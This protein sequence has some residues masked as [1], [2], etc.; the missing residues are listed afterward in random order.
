MI[1]GATSF[2]APIYIEVFME[3]ISIKHKY[4]GAI[5][6]FFILNILN[7]FMLTTQTLNR[8]IAPFNHTFVGTINAMVGNFATLFIVVFL[9][10]IV[11]KKARKRLLFLIWFSLFLNVFVFGLGLFNLFFGTSFSFA[12]TALYLN[13]PGGFILGV[14][15]QAFLELFTYFRIV[16]FLPTIIMVVLYHKFKKEDLSQIRF[17]IRVKRAVIFTLGAAILLFSSFSVFYMQFKNNL[18]INSLKSTFATQNLGVYPFYLGEVLGHTFEVD[19]K[20]FL[21]IKNEEDLANAFNKYNK[22]Q[23]EYINFFNGKTYS[24]RLTTQQA[25]PDLFVDEAIAKGDSLHGILEGRNLVLVQIESMNHFLFELEATNERLVFL[26]QLKEQSFVF[27]NYFSNVGMGVSSDAELTVFTGLY[28]TGNRTLYWDFN[29]KR[30]ELNS[31]PNL[32]NEQGYHTEAV[33]GNKENFYNR[34]NVYPD[35]LGFN[36][37]HSLE[38]FVKDGY[39]IEDGFLYNEENNSVHHSPWVSDFHHADTVSKIGNNLSEMN[40]SFM[41]FS[42]LMMP[43]TPFHF[44]PNGEREDIFPQFANQIDSLTL[45]YINNVD[46]YDQTIKRFFINDQNEDQTL[47]NTVYIFYGDHSSSLKNDDLGTLFNR[48][49]CRMELRKFLQHTTA[50]IYV[51]GNEMINFGEYQFRK[52]LLTGEQD[53]VRSNVDMHRTI[54]ELFN[55]PIGDEA[56]FGVHGLSTEPTFALDNRL[57]DVVLD[58]YFFSIRNKKNRH[59]ETD[60]ISDE[61]FYYI[62]RFKL[63]SDLMLSEIDMQDRV[64]KALFRYH[65]S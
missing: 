16:V 15:M 65:R 42:L 62:T 49:L 32:F 23:R 39:V 36:N 34:N 11:I 3:N 64:N 56:Y 41:I 60:V 26:N 29:E 54:I 12:A 33:H 59:P 7:T 24:N 37:F 18:P 5:A 2:V 1:L 50:F 27:N 58:E 55:L 48:D 43:H 31:L 9:A 8:Y 28:P 6:I 35:L 63:L 10:F 19:L 57:M 53:L 61:M 21:E 51:P 20:E 17:D 40:E 44:G 13:P 46:Y 25:V 4:Y 45:R 22:N 52:G 14:L 30:F 47:D 38:D